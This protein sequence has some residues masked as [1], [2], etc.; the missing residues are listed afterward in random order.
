M[1]PLNDTKNAVPI[2]RHF[3]EMLIY[4][5]RYACGRRSYSVNNTVAY[6]TA[7]LPSI[8]DNTLMVFDRDMREHDRMAN[9]SG[10]QEIWGDDCDRVDWMEF[11]RNVQAEIL[12]RKG[13]KHGNH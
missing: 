4:A 9:D 8:S 2:T 7:L 6:I 12:K 10:N 3:E 11:W 13:D 1:I 5:E